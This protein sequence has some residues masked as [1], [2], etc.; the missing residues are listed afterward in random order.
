[1]PI[2]GLPRSDIANAGDS[3]HQ[4]GGTGPAGFETGL[5]SPS[6]ILTMSMYIEHLPQVP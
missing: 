6:G 1:M 4:C 5:Q 2:P 3:A